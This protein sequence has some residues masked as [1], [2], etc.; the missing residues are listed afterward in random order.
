MILE[1][2]MTALDTLNAEGQN[3]KQGAPRGQNVLFGQEKFGPFGPDS[4]CSAKSV[5]SPC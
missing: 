1:K 3:G 2:I 4:K 5:T